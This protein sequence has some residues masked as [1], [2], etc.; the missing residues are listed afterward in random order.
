MTGSR[1]TV[2]D[3][4]ERGLLERI[5]RRLETAS[6]AGEIG[7]GDDAALLRLPSNGL[8]LTVDGLVEGV[9]FDFAYCS[10]YDAGWKAMAVNVSDI[11]AMG[12]VPAHAVVALALRPDTAVA[13]VD[14]LLEGLIAAGERWDVGIVGGDVGAAAEMS[15][16]VTVT[17]SVEGEPVRRSGANAGDD[18]L[19]TGALGGSAAGLRLLQAG[20]ADEDPALRRLATRH[21]RPQARVREGGLLRAAGAT[22]MIDVSDGLAVDLWNLLQASGAGCDLDEDEI[23]IDG[24]LEAAA[25]VLGDVD[26]FETALLGGEDFELIVTMPAGRTSEA[27]AAVAEAGTRTTRLGTVTDGGCLVRGEPLDAWKEK[28]WQHLRSR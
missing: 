19:V 21:L 5:G 23:P 8:L 26:P 18:I 12:G 1:G 9:D 6:A 4:G 3:L 15:I 24:D 16:A 22:A 7:M 28:G 14:D 2:S 10:G 17:G 13:T 25:A 11:A 27:V 20:L